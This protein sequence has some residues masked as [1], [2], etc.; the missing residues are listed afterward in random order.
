[1]FDDV[2]FP[3]G[4]VWAWPCK[5]HSCPDY[6]KLWRLQKATF[7]LHLQERGSTYVHSND[8]ILATDTVADTE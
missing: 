1:M 6:G 3:L 4:H 5:L 8:T 7:V 2:D